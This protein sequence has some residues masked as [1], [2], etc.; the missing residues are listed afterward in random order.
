VPHQVV[1]VLSPGANAF[2]FAV[3]CEVFGLRRP[4]LGPPLY[5]HELAAVSS[6]VTVDS[7]W[8][9][10]VDADLAALRTADTVVVPAGPRGSDQDPQLLD[11]LR[12][13][14]DR[15][16][17]I[18]SFCTGAFVLAA[19]GILDG[20]PVS[21]HWMHARELA[22]RFP[23]L[24]VDN[25]VL[26]VDDG[27]VLTSAGTAAAIDLALHIVRLDHG[28]QVANEVARRMVVPPHRDGGQAQFAVAP[29]P[30][31]VDDDPLGPVMITI[32]PG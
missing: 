13:A 32:S 21:T 12:R 18:V 30:R 26:Y 6:P 5:N 28:A 1:T 7:G 11:A 16:A 3:A 14:Y 15:G 20:R 10:H 31:T 24:R 17:R 27:Q 9:V 23:V 25:D 29:V 19:A 22:Q 4:E 2:E 8:Q